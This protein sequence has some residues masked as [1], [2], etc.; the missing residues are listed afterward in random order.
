MNGPPYSLVTEHYA[1][2]NPHEEYF[3]DVPRYGGTEGTV[4]AKDDGLGT[5]WSL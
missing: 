1:S 3:R 2:P 4:H 5:P